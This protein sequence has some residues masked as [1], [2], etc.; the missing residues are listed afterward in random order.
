MVSHNL[1]NCNVSVDAIAE[2]R[3]KTQET[4]FLPEY[5]VA[6]AQTRKNPVSG[7]PCVSHPLII[8][9]LKSLL[10]KQSPLLAD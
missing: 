7:H 3:T 4:G 2:L 6:I 5:L 10:I 8:W 1:I 9:R